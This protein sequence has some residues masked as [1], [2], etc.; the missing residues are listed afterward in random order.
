[1]WSLSVN[2]AGRFLYSENLKTGI[3]GYVSEYLNFVV[4][5][6][7]SFSIE[8]DGQ[9][10]SLVE[11]DQINSVLIDNTSTQSLT[12]RSDVKPGLNLLP[13][14]TRQNIENS[15]VTK[16]NM[17]TNNKPLLGTEFRQD[18]A[19]VRQNYI[20]HSIS[21]KILESHFDN[22]HAT[23]NSNLINVVSDIHICDGKL[24]LFNK[25]FNI[26]VGDISDS[27]VTDETIK[28]IYVI[29][30]HELADVLPVNRNKRNREWE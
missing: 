14:E 20:P 13:Q 10:F 28:G 3:S 22:V 8:I 7:N 24:P 30:N 5:V 19:K 18:L 9:N 2:L 17:P 21:P 6:A 15:L 4:Q 26:Y 1:M 29:G 27:N 12:F 25:N 23:T 11:E 16:A